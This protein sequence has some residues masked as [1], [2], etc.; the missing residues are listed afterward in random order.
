MQKVENSGFERCNK[1]NDFFR[2]A[3]D[4]ILIEI[5]FIQIQNPKISQSGFVGI[6]S[7]KSLQILH[8]GGSKRIDD[9]CMRCLSKM[10]SLQILNVAHCELITD[11]GLSFLPHCLQTLNIKDNPSITWQGLTRLNFLK[12]LNI[13][14][15]KHLFQG[16]TDSKTIEDYSQEILP[17]F[18]N[19]QKLTISEKKEKETMKKDA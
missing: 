14:G 8:V 18:R 10:E 3:H 5:L 16:G 15:C 11:K 6:E 2:N 12:I 1:K 7:L 9:E 13:A 17:L 4:Q 19:M